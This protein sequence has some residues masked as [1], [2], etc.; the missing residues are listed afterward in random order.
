MTTDERPTADLQPRDPIGPAGIELA[1]GPYRGALNPDFDTPAFRSAL[2][3]PR[4]FASDP[5]ARVLL[6]RR[7]LVVVVSVPVP[8]S[9]RAG[10][11]VK[12]FHASGFKRLKTLFVPGKAARAW[13]GAAACRAHAVPTPLPLAYLERRAR[14]LVV[15]GYYISTYL[16]DAVEIRSLL[17][18]LPPDALGRLL[19]ELAKFLVFCHNEGILHRDLSDGNILVRSPRPGAYDLCL[20]DTNRIR[21]RCTI[22]VLVRLRNLIRLGVPP[23]Y[24]DLFLRLYLGD[25]RASRPLILWYRANKAWYAGFGAFK[26]KLRLRRLAERL[27]I[28]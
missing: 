20:I 18:D 25:A 26:K 16:P 2:A 22:P 19:A 17:R 27:G 8:P 7:N 1:I 6:D 15:E 21:V 14:S 23:A 4:A 13:R 9:G 11:V 12:M 3:D 24:Q 5:S 10:A 28:Q